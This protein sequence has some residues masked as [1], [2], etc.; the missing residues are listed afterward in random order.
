MVVAGGGCGGNKTRNSSSESRGVVDGKAVEQNEGRSMY[1]RQRTM[2][3]GRLVRR[4]KHRQLE[5]PLTKFPNPWL[6]NLERIISYQHLG[7]QYRGD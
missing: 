4:P 2:I 7:G 1:L 6:L 3:Q 5:L